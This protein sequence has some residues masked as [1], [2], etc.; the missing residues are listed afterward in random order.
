MLDKADFCDNFAIADTPLVFCPL[1]IYRTGFHYRLE[2]SPMNT[3][4]V[5]LSVVGRA[6]AN[7]PA[8]VLAAGNATLVLSQKG[9][10]VLSLQWRTEADSGEYVIADQLT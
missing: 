3:C 5:A 6:R 4:G 7:V 9:C 8:R 10:A 2:F 1:L